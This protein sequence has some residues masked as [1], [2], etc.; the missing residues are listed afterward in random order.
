MVF[1]LRMIGLVTL[2]VCLQV[3]PAVA[4]NVD[5]LEESTEDQTQKNKFGVNLGL[6]SAVGFAGGSYS[7]VF[8]ESFELEFGMGLGAS[9]TQLSFMP[10]FCVGSHRFHYVFGAGLSLGISIDSSSEQTTEHYAFR[11][12]SLWLN[13]DMLGFEYRLSSDIALGVALGITAG[14]GGGERTN[15]CPLWPSEGR[16]CSWEPVQG[17]FGPQARLVV[18]NWF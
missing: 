16:F 14:L 17:V 18:A 9:G 3:A 10:K 2:C 12:T 7:R 8:S 1:Q 5:S 4:E 13:V 6:F 15:H 11:G